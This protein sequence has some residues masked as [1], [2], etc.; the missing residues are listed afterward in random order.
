MT[1]PL[2]SLVPEKAVPETSMVPLVIV[3]ETV[4]VKVTSFPVLVTLPSAH[5]PSAPWLQFALMT[6]CGVVPR[7]SRT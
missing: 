1:A 4:T 7:L 5:R 2:I 6:L 3:A